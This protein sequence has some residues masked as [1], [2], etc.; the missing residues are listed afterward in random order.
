[1]SLR[2][3]TDDFFNARAAREARDLVMKMD[4]QSAREFVYHVV[5]DV[6]EDTIEKNQ[7]TLQGHLDDVIA[8]RLDRIKKATVK[9]AIAKKEGAVGFAQAVSLIE[10]AVGEWEYHE[11]A[12]GGNPKNRGQFSSSWG[13][14]SARRPNYARGSRTQAGMSDWDM[15]PKVGNAPSQR[16]A[17]QMGFPKK[18]SAATSDK[19]RA[20][21]MQLANFVENARRGVDQPGN[22]DVTLRVQDRRTGEEWNVDRPLT[23]ANKLAGAWDPEKENLIGARV[24][25]KG[26]TVGNAAYN[27][28]GSL[29]ASQSL[30]TVDR[31][32]G[33]FAN[34]WNRPGDGNER[35]YNRVGAG[36]KLLGDVGSATGS[37]QLQVAAAF[38]RF[39]GS[40]GSEAEQIFGP[41]TRKLAYRYRG[42]EKAPD[43]SMVRE[44]EAANNRAKTLSIDTSKLSPV[45]QAAHRISNERRSATFDEREDG[46]RRITAYLMQ[47]GPGAQGAAGRFGLHLAA[48]NTPPSEGV[49]ID[50]DGKI[51]TQAVGYGDD[52]YLPF[53]LRHLKGLKDG[54]YIRT[55][56]VGGPTTEDIYTGLM[57]GARQMTVASRSGTFQVTFEEDFRGG[58]RHNDKAK[59]M[60]KRYEQLLNAIQS[61]QVERM[62]ISPNV[63][64]ALEQQVKEK[65]AEDRIEPSRKDLREAIE[66]RITEYKSD[67]DFT[68]DDDKL[69]DIAEY[70]MRQGGLSDK[71]I[72]AYKNQMRTEMMNNKEYTYK[73]NG[74]GYQAAL[75]ALQEQFPYYLTVRSTPNEDPEAKSTRDKG[76]VPG[77]SI[78]PSGAG[79]GKFATNSKL[80]F[81]SQD[82]G[83]YSAALQRRPQRDR[84]ETTEA[85][86]TS[87]EKTETASSRPS[88]FQAKLGAR[89]RSQAAERVV[90]NIRGVQGA[91]TWPAL[92]EA[93][94]AS[95]QGIFGDWFTKPG[96]ADKLH[97]TFTQIRNQSPQLADRTNQGGAWDEY[98]KPVDTGPRGDFTKLGKIRSLTGEG[99]LADLDHEGL[100]RELQA[101]ET[102]ALLD[103]DNPPLDE[104]REAVAESGITGTFPNSFQK[105]RVRDQHLANVRSALGH[106]VPHTPKPQRETGP[107][108]TLKLGPTGTLPVSQPSED[109]VEAEIV[110]EPRREGGLTTAKFLDQAAQLIDDDATGTMDTAYS[111]RLRQ[112]AE[113]YRVASDDGDT[114]EIERLNQESQDLLQVAMDVVGPHRYGR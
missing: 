51:V 48:G 19:Y 64:A 73:L 80:M 25:P 44:Y 4:E 20:E 84:E 6:L 36:S 27:L 10:K 18:V 101:A 92:R 26:M 55:R 24:T 85:S 104:V 76:Y 99:S 28:T 38:G 65:F 39:V 33:S 103:G 63:R 109:V 98:T 11:H 88:A 21:Y 87:G 42:T 14:G 107:N 49:I 74:R 34:D 102:F 111:P 30:D 100:K 70:R 37:S 31:G 46:R 53:N 82:Q 96:N 94:A 50:A 8:K 2:I 12:R 62:D 13:S 32:F 35:L 9:T 1:M 110:E 67:P 61:E 54:E 71:D 69:L 83:K 93:S 90:G 59:R 68:E 16:A 112:L 72:V 7:R 114:A 106:E 57:S 3:V 81:R 86:F 23:D 66:A 43:S 77:G 78:K 15:T 58:R 75:E 52:H 105:K 91:E 40:H 113:R 5:S 56:S 79:A 95:Q 29:G 45:Q 22:H 108:G 17:G 60:V 47:K 41:P 97:D 89:K